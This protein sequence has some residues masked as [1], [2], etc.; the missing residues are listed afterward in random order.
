LDSHDLASGPGD[1]LKT[2]GYV[3]KVEYLDQHPEVGSPDIADHLHRL[4]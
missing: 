4:I 1:L 2:I 3:P